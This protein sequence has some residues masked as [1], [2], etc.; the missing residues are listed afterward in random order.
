MPLP[1]HTERIDRALAREQIY[2]TIRDW[3]VRGILE[4]G[5]K[6]LDVELALRLGVSRTP[7]REALQRLQDEGLVQIARNRW[8]RVSP[9]RLDD[10]RTF[11]PI[12]W[13]LE[14]LAAELCGPVLVPEDYRT[15]RAVND[16]LTRALRARDPVAASAA[17]NEFHGV[18]I[19]RT[20]NPELI[21][22]LEELKLK[23]RRI[24]IAYF[25]GSVVAGRS[26][27]EH[28]AIVTALER[29]DV[30]GAAEAVEVNWR[31]ALARLMS[32]KTRPRS[33]IPS[34]RQAAGAGG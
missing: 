2:A 29:K 34:E 10:A 15:M 19:S 12:V 16:R 9:L 17:D 26:V 7:V 18:L 27:T 21:R 8:T 13:A 31:S 1:I 30:R 23:L 5:E 28:R 25:R 32:A 3:I 6:M 4:P 24:E 20:K 11:Y 22:L 14:R 33:S